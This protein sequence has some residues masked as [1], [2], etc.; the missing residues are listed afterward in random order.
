MRPLS[1]KTKLTGTACLLLTGLLVLLGTATLKFFAGEYR[2]LIGRQQFAMVSEV[3]ATLDQKL[4]FGRHLIVAT[5]ASIPPAILTDP[6]QVQ[7]FLNQHLGLG[8]TQFFDNGVFLFSPAGRLV[9]EWPFKPDRRGRDYAFRDYFRR[10][11]EK[12]GPVISVPYFSS[13]AHHHPAVSFTAPLFDHAGHLAGVLAGSVDLTK[14]NFLGNFSRFRIGKNGYFYLFST[15][16]LMIMHP[17]PK[18]VLQNDIPPGAN[19][20]LDKAIDGFEGSG[21]TIN[22]RGL[23]M[24]VSFKRLAA[25]N[26]ILAA[27]YPQ[28]EAY[29]PLRRALRLTLVGVLGTLLV[30]TLVIWLVMRRQIEPLVHLTEQVRTLAAR[31]E[32]RRTLEVS[33]R[34]EIG[35]LSAA[36]NRLLGEVDEQTA[37]SR[38]RLDFLQTILDSIPLPVFYKD[39][40]GHYLGCN[41][42]FE[43]AL[44][45]PRAELEGKTVRDLLPAAEAD[46]HLHI[47][48]ELLPQTEAIVRSFEQTLTLADGESHEI[49]Y[50]KSAYRNSRGEPAGLVATMIDITERKAIEI[51]L[52]EQREFSQ[53]LLQNSAV[54]CFVL[55]ANHQVL[56]WTRACEE[57]TGLAAAE[58]LGSNR[59]WKAFYDRPRPCLADLILAGDL[60]QTLDLYSSF[61][62]SQLIPEGLQAEGWFP[63]VG[64]RPRYLFFE[65][66]PIR[67]QQ[68]E[69]I[70]A[71]ETLQD[72]TGLKQAE[73]ALRESEQSF[74]ALIERSPD[75]I[76]VH[77]GNQVILGNLAASR[78]FGAAGPE[79]LAGRDIGDLVA[80]ECREEILTANSPGRDRAERTPLSRGA[81]SAQRRHPGGGRDQLGTGLL[82]RPVDGPIDCAGYYRTQGAAGEDLAAGQLRRPDR[83]A[84]PDAVSRPAAP[85]DRTGAAGKLSGGGTVYRPRPLQGDQRHPRP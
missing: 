15:D 10:T 32:L 13:Q 26:W 68:G 55:D 36:F 20:L 14:D 33:S 81:D 57:L 80:P 11:V 28:P 24:L 4:D 75:A 74:R 19:R 71:I 2:D 49:L 77:R 5:A 38:E 6:D 70:A 66:A 47:D 8:T 7:S 25:T 16:R 9:A 51:A 50:F 82:R 84:Q 21:E 30:A 85:G 45:I 53:N 48:A 64:G 46:I 43:L 60:E 23:A 3:A 40:A 27:N 67:N 79:Q 59:H 12:G 62:N 17:D 29:A 37:L 22:S 78:L 65:A 52:A 41:A 1:L 63:R 58:V 72:L 73:Q 31:P 35:T 18:R 61:G 56:I 34:D 54:P 83:V 39:R 69:L 42:A 44:G 76:L